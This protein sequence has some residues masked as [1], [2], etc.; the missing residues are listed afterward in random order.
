MILIILF[1]LYL[2]LVNFDINIE[3]DPRIINSYEINEKSISSI[4]K[5]EMILDEIKIIRK[6]FNLLNIKNDFDLFIK[7]RDFELSYIKNRSNLSS[8]EEYTFFDS[9]N[10]NINDIWRNK[11]NFKK[12][13][14][15]KIFFSGVMKE[16]GEKV[17]YIY[18]YD[19]LLSI[20][21][22]EFFGESKVLKIFEDGILLINKKNQFEVI[23]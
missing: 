21:E 20:K 16:K 2:F 6:N 22:N 19:S 3:E 10:I 9:Y 13:E 1:S 18:F 4:L 5:T 7:E 23:L 11:K 17:A 15:E 12:F 8:E 14:Q